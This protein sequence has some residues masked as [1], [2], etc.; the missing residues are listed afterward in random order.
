MQNPTANTAMMRGTR[1]TRRHHH[2]SFI[3]YRVPGASIPR[4]TTKPVGGG[5]K[6]IRALR[7]KQDLLRAAW[8]KISTGLSLHTTTGI[9]FRS[10]TGESSVISGRH[11]RKR[12]GEQ[13]QLNR[14]GESTLKTN[15]RR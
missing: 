6:G 13:T 11:R 4:N 9:P 1:N 8:R 12:P 5:I 10:L 7:G 2:R 3:A 15:A 14:D